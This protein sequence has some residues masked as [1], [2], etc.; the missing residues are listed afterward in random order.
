MHLY[1]LNMWYDQLSMIMNVS[2]LLSKSKMHTGREEICVC[3]CRKSN[4][5]ERP[6][7]EV[8]RATQLQTIGEHLGASNMLVIAPLAPQLAT[9]THHLDYV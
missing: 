2:S 7:E 6:Q 1:S 8:S 5:H 4:D 3:M 9:A